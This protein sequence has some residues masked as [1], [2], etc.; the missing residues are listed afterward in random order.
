MSDESI[1]KLEDHAVVTKARAFEL[2]EAIGA[3]KKTMRDYVQS[4][5]SGTEKRL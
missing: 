3:L 1:A 2:F 5:K 4:M